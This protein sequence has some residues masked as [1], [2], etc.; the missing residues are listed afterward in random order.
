VNP[1]LLNDVV[2]TLHAIAAILFTIFQCLIFERD[3]QRVSNLARILVGLVAVFVIIAIIPAALGTIEWLDYLYYFSYIKLGS[4]LIKY[5]PQAFMNYRRKSTEGWSIGNI[6]LDFTGGV[7]SILQMFLLS[8]NHD[9]W[10]SIFGDPT[11]FGLGFFSICFDVL[12]MVQHYCLYRRFRGFKP[13][14]ETTQQPLKKKKY[15]Y[16]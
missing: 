11:K 1:V 12:F 5:I 14:E 7:F 13:I 9:D 16:C 6:L 15:V 8:Y 3:R 4:T 2:F 10:N